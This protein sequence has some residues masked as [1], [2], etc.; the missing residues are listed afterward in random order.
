MRVVALYI[1]YPNAN[2]LDSGG[3]VSL[4]ICLSPPEHLFVYCLSLSR[5]IKHVNMAH[6]NPPVLS[7]CPGGTR[8]HTLVFS[9]NVKL[10]N[11]QT[12]SNNSSIISNTSLC[13]DKYCCA[14]N[15]GPAFPVAICCAC[16]QQIS[17]TTH[18]L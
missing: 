12:L 1:P 6:S 7:N 17:I 14:S 5:Q 3:N 4:S 18:F 8:R 10:L 2:Q 15:L 16:L 13:T 9:R 11:G